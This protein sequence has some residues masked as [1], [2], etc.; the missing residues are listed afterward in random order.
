M[1]A[2]TAPADATAPAGPPAR[3]RLRRRLAVGLAVVVALVATLLVLDRFLPGTE[4]ISSPIADTDLPGVAPSSGWVEASVPLRADLLAGLPRLDGDDAP[5]GTGTEKPLFVN[6]WAS[7]CGPC[8][9]E[10]PL[11]EEL[12]LTS[13]D[14][15]VVGVSRD[16]RRGFA[17]DVVDDYDLTFANYLDED[18]RFAEELAPDVPYQFLPASFLVEDGTITWVHIGP[19]DSVA[20]IQDDVRARVSPAPAA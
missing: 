2:P 16:V 11:V 4:E 15:E 20:E 5:T 13:D 1:P 17:E 14:L 9:R 12:A 7:Y 8:A 6:V 18:S 19:F 3:G 10:L